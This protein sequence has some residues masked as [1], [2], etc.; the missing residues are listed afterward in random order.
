MLKSLLQK[1]VQAEVPEEGHELKNT[2]PNMK[3]KNTSISL[4]YFA[5]SSPSLAPQIDHRLA[6]LATSRGF[7]STA[8]SLITRLEL[9]SS[10]HH[11]HLHAGRITFTS[12]SS[13][14]LFFLV[15]TPSRSRAG[16]IRRITEILAFPLPAQAP[17]GTSSTLACRLSPLSW[18]LAVGTEVVLGAGDERGG[19]GDGGHCEADAAVVG[20]VRRGFL[21]FCY[22][23]NELAD[24]PSFIV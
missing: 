10:L 14:F 24:S 6:A 16:R 20:V 21:I 17:L 4:P 9:D 13:F 2:S 22:L 1:P 12:R 18:V 15:L 19:G 8:P 11:Q 5:P 7:I 3:P 23:S